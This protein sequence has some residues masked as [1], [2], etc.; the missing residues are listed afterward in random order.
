VN[1]EQWG[2][3][4]RGNQPYGELAQS[5]EQA[6]TG[7][8]AAKLTYAFPATQDDYVVFKQS[9]SISTDPNTFGA[10]VYGDGS[11]HYVNL[12]IEGRRRAG[13]VSLFRK[14]RWR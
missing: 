14:V 11:G 10:W 12:W 2:G 5:T 4:A 6:K 3:W 13:L 8:Y 9:R 1:F 7:Q